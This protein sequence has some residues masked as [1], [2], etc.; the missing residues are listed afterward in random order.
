M[1]LLSTKYLRGKSILE[2]IRKS[3]DYIW[4][5]ITKTIKILKDGY[6]YRIGKGDIS[7]RYHRWLDREPLCLC[8]PYVGI[9]DIQLRLKD[10]FYNNKWNFE[11][12]YTYLPQEVYLQIQATPVVEH[13]DMEDTIIWVNELN[14]SYST[15]VGYRWLQQQYQSSI[16][17]P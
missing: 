10:V 12:L 4:H 13:V 15:K 16:A 11:N 3:G 5:L 9:D 1:Q 6:K 8:V 17:I 14:G 7:F 2:A